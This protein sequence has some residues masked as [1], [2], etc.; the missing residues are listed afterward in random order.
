MAYCLKCAVSLIEQNLYHARCS[1]LRA[2]PQGGSSACPIRPSIVALQAESV[3]DEIYKWLPVL[4]WFNDAKGYG[5]ITPDEKGEDLFAHFS[6]IKMD[7]FKSLKEGQRV[8]FDVVDGPKASR[9]RTS[10]RLSNNCF[11]PKPRCF[12]PVGNSGFLLP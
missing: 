10:C 4:K 3:S 2:F 9:P 11:T 6:A 8:T 12:L 7:G 5:F 1:T